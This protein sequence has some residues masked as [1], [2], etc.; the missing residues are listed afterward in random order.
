MKTLELFS[1]CLKL[2]KSPDG[3]GLKSF[4]PSVFLPDCFHHDI[5]TLFQKNTSEKKH[6]S[7]DN[8]EISGPTDRGI[9]YTISKPQRADR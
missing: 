5:E 3:F 8:V 1:N 6:I 2:T 9:R 7:S 4:N